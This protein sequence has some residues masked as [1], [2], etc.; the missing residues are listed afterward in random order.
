MRSADGKTRGF[1][2]GGAWLVILLLDLLSTCFFAALLV[3]WSTRNRIDPADP[4]PILPQ[5][6]DLSLIG[7]AALLLL[8]FVGTACAVLRRRNSPGTVKGGRAVSVLRLILLFLVLLASA[9]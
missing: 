5:P 7:S 9:V 1:G 6:S 4:G 3:E 8:S 2:P